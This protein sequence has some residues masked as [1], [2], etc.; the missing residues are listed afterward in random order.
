M[1]GASV[2]IGATNGGARK[3]SDCVSHPVVVIHCV[4]HRLELG[5]LDATKE[6]PYLDH[7]EQTTKRIYKL[8]SFSPKR[9]SHLHTIAEI[10]IKSLSCTPI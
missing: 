6:L 8:H 2:N 10:W 3:L 9:R 5:V 7:F 4:A 1:D